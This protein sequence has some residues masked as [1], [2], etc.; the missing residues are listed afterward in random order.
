MRRM[1][2]LLA[3]ILF[4]SSALARIPGTKASPVPLPHDSLHELS[5]SIQ[6]LSKNVSRAVVQVFSTAYAL[7]DDDSTSS[8][9]AAGVVT[10]PKEE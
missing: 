1:A 8:G 7:S 2:R 9:N 10:K 3:F 6:G 5:D 4:V